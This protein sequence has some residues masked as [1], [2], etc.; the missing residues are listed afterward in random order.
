MQYRRPRRL[1]TWSSGNGAPVIVDVGIVQVL[2]TRLAVA[3]VD[4]AYVHPGIGDELLEQIR[5]R[6]RWLTH[7][8]VM[9]YSD[10]GR[11]FAVF[12]AH[13][14]AKRITKADAV[15]WFTIDTD[16]DEADYTPMPF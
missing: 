8:P 11:G 12:Q 15:E 2:N 10:D 4:S 7:F 14:F 1:S 6:L 13:E 9:L 3:F 5:I 16:K